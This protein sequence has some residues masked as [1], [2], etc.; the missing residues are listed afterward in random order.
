MDEYPFESRFV[1]IAGQRMHYVDEGRLT[2]AKAS[3]STTSISP[4]SSAP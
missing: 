1:E 4:T 2:S 3:S